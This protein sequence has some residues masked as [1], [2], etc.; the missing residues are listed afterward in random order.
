MLQEDCGEKSDD[1]EEMLQNESEN[2]LDD[3]DETEADD[4]EQA[5]SSELNY[6]HNEVEGPQASADDEI[7]K[8]SN[9]PIPA[10]LMFHDV[11]YLNFDQTQSSQLYLRSF[12]ERWYLAGLNYFRIETFRLQY[13]QW[14]C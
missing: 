1:S 9:N 12:L 14:W 7:L 3:I 5:K 8:I 2:E 11:G 13:R 4:N 6:K 10:V